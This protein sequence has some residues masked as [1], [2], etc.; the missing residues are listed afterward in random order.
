MSQW[1]PIATAPKNRHVDLWAKTWR[2][3]FDDFIYQRFPRCVWSSGDQMINRAPY[4]I[5]L[6]EGWYPTHWMPIPEGP[7]GQK[8]F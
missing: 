4:W 6:G 3:T 7:D 1:Q 5:N 8:E 2:A